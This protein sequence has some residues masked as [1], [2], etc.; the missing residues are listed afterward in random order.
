MHAETELSFK[1]KNNVIEKTCYV[2]NGR[3]Q[4]SL[5]NREDVIRLLEAWCIGHNGFSTHVN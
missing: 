2:N 5:L 4:G 3:H 1:D